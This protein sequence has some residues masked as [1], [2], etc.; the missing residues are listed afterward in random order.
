M[1]KVLIISLLVICF[2]LSACGAS[3]EG[4]EISKNAKIEQ[5]E[6]KFERKLE[7]SEINI[8][9]LQVL[10]HSRLKTVANENGKLLRKNIR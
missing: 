7:E 6:A 3:P 5:S 9:A 10:G 1:K 8:K 4:K 2:S